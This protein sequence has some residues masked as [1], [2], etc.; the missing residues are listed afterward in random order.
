[1][2]AFI[3]ALTVGIVSACGGTGPEG[4]VKS[5]GDVITEQEIRE[6]A[7]SNAY[8]LINLRRPRFLRAQG[9]R[10]PTSI[11]NNSQSSK[12]P[13]VYVDGHWYG[14]PEEL[15]NLPTVFVKEVRYVSWQD[16]NL[17]YGFGHDAG[18]IRVTTKRWSN[19]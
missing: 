17:Q 5:D 2:K 12:L 1:M 6:T 7:A 9:A 4:G 15:R 14:Y 19:E 16:A 3:L 10:G 18:I 13:E 11:L 8:E